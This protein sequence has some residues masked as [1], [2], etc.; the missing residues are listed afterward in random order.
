VAEAEAVEV[1]AE[2]ALADLLRRMV[3]ALVDAPEQVHIRG[4]VDGGVLLLEVGVAKG[5]RPR[6]LSVSATW[7]P[8]IHVC[9]KKDVDPLLDA[10]DATIAA[11]RL[12]VA[13][14]TERIELVKRRC[15][16]QHAQMAKR[17]AELEGGK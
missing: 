15:K 3:V 8:D 13:T 5:E 7:H 2:M 10:Q 6:Y 16:T 4:S 17:I 11:L 14:L 1:S 9:R 12:E